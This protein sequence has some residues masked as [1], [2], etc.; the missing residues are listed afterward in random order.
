AGERPVP[1]GDCTCGRS[2]STRTS[3]DSA[4]YE[5]RQRHESGSGRRHAR[6]ELVELNRIEQRNRLDDLHPEEPRV[7]VRV[8]LAVQSREFKSAGPYF[9]RR[10]I[11]VVA[12]P[13]GDTKPGNYSF[14]PS[15]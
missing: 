8:L 9:G 5:G 13:A 7:R 6:P 15:Y 14:S 11:G 2:A 12:E 4:D 10:R 3:R 1:G